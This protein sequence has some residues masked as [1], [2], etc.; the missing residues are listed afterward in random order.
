MSEF[1]LWFWRPIAEAL[2]V[3]ALVTVAGLLLFCW[4]WIARWVEAR[5]FEKQ[6]LA[7]AKKAA[8]E[9]KAKATL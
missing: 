7:A 5:S 3:F 1:W 4:V 8:V 9:A 2:G 6:Q